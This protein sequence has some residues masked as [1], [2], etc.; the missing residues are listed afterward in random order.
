MFSGSPASRYGLPRS[1]AR[2][3]GT[4]TR[5]MVHPLPW[6][7][8]HRAVAGRVAFSQQPPNFLRL[9]LRPRRGAS[10]RL[11]LLGSE[12]RLGTRCTTSATAG[13]RTRPTSW[14]ACK[15]RRFRISALTEKPATSA[16]TTCS[17]CTCGGGVW[18][19]RSSTATRGRVR[20]APHPPPAGDGRL[21]TL[22]PGLRR[23]R[24]KPPPPKSAPNSP[25][26]ADA[27]SKEAHAILLARRRTWTPDSAPGCRLRVFRTPAACRAG[28]NPSDSKFRQ[29]VRCRR[30]DRPFRRLRLPHELLVVERSGGDRRIPRRISGVGTY[31][32]GQGAHLDLGID[33]LEDSRARGDGWK[34]GIGARRID[35]PVQGGDPAVVGPASQQIADVDDERAG[36]ERRLGPRPRPWSSPAAVPERLVGTENRQGVEVGVGAGTQ[37]APGAGASCWSG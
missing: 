29:A 8:A 23:S 35:D 2:W 20:V 28:A 26:P 25:E 27:H 21:R 15:Q 31:G 30:P 10:N 3:T 5:A 14:K 1:T 24:L 4:P 9:G 7:M 36:D 11:C 12:R 18:R 37:A 19:I 16:P 34:P 32:T 22:A 13:R 6:H 33:L 17:P